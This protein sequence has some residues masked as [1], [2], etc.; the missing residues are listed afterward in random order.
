MKI[1]VRYLPR[2]YVGV[3]KRI[4]GTNQI[5]HVMAR[6]LPGGFNLRPFLHR[7]RGVKIA[8]NVWIGDDVYLAGD[9]PEDVEIHEGAAI[10]TRCTIIGYAKGP[11]KIIV[12]KNAAIG[13]GSVAIRN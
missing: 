5:L 3:L 7:L 13:A 4:L 10:A 11:G 1:R 6:V 8:D 9:N 2:T 12:E